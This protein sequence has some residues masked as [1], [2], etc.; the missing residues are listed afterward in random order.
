VTETHDRPAAPAPRAYWL[1]WAATLLFFAGFYTLLV[2]M[3][4]QMTAVG[5]SDT[6]IGIV[7]GAFGFAS[8]ALRLPAGWAADRIGLR[9]LLLLG[10]A[11]LAGGSLLVPLSDG[12]WPLFLLRAAQ[13]AGY[14]IFTTSGTAAI[15]RMTPPAVRGSRIAL[16]GAAANVAMTIVPAATTAVLASAPLTFSFLTAAA[17]AGLA[18]LLGVTA[19]GAQQA[20]IA[21]A[22]RVTRRDLQRLLLPMLAAALAG[23]GFAAF[24]QFVPLLAE[25]R[26]GVNAGLLY[27]I[28]G[29]S[30]ILSRLL[31]GRLV[32]RWS[33]RRSLAASALLMTFGLALLAL[34][35]AWPAALAAALIAFGSGFSH[36][37]LIAMHA[38]LLPD[39]PG[40]ATA[41][42]YL[43]FDL[44]VGLS[45]ALY[46]RALDLGG[47]PAL[48]LFAAVLTLLLMLGAP[49]LQRR[50]LR[51]SVA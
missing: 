37:V 51:D 35:A 1:L 36:P 33:L 23:A 29:V 43:G 30:I 42:F 32:D 15:L 12:V 50:V 4:R 34:D 10:A 39:A 6:E 3:P 21:A 24:F 7:L 18:A 28:Y 44:G 26:A 17:F 45:S 38:R 2:P 27:S 8:L 41:V 48:Y 19:A 49:L 46:G 22:P 20:A 9:P 31:T 47:L 40:T 11:L 25:R 5:L 16:F 14:V 13:A